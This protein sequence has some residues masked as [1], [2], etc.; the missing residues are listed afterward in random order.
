MRQYWKGRESSPMIQGTENL[1]PYD[2]DFFPMSKRPSVENLRRV[3]R[4]KNSS[5]IAHE[6]NG[7]YDPANVYIPQRPLLSHRLSQR[8][9]NSTSDGD[10]ASNTAGQ[11]VISEQPTE[12]TEN[13]DTIRTSLSAKDQISPTKSSLSKTNA[14]GEIWDDAS[15][16]LKSVTFD[17]APPQVNEYEMSTPD[18]ST[19]TSDVHEGSEGSDEAEG[20]LDLSFDPDSS[21]DRD[22]SFDASLEDI[23]KTPV[24]LPEEWRFMSPENA[25]ESQANEDGDPFTE[26]QEDNHPQSAR[27]SP[28]DESNPERR[29]LPPLPSMRIAQSPRQQR[30][31][32]THPAPASSGQS[33]DEELEYASVSLED[34]LRV[35]MLDGS[36]R[37]HEKDET[38]LKEENNISEKQNKTDNSECKNQETG[39]GHD[40]ANGLPS[41]RISRE[42]I[43]RDIRKGDNYLDESFEYPSQIEASPVPPLSL[44]EPDVPIPTLEEEDEGDEMESGSVI[45]KQEEHD[46]DDDE[47]HAIPEYSDDHHYDHSAAD[48]DR[49]VH[50]SN[51]ESQHSKQAGEELHDQSAHL[52]SSDDSVATAIDPTQPAHEGPPGNV[53]TG[54]KKE[55]TVHGDTVGEEASEEAG[56]ENK[57]TDVSDDEFSTPG[58]VVR[59][60]IEEE[61]KSEEMNI[62]PPAATVKAPGSKLRIRPSLTKADTAAMAATRR[63]VSGH[64]PPPTISFDND[65]P[66][67]S[68]R[69]AQDDS[70]LDN[71]KS[72]QDALHP[73]VPQ[74]QSSFLKLDIPFSIQEEDS[75]GLGLDKEFDRVMETQKVAQPTLS[76]GS[77]LQADSYVP[78][79][80]GY[81][82]RQNTKV[83]VASSDVGE[84]DGGEES[85]PKPANEAKNATP[86]EKP[87]TPSPRKPSQP[88]WTTVPWNGKQR[89]VSAKQGPSGLPRKKPVP[90]PVPPLPG[91]ASNVEEALAIAEENEASLNETMEDGEERGRVFVKVVGIKDLDLPLPKGMFA[92]RNSTG[93]SLFL[94]FN[95][96]GER[97]YF[98]LT[99]D[100]GLH[101]VT[102]SW[103][104]LGKS[105]PIGQ[106]FELIVQKDLEFQLTLQMKMDESKFHT[107]EPSAPS[108]SSTPVRQKTSAFSRVF[109]SPRKK[110]EMELKQQAA[111]Q[112]QPRTENPSLA[113]WQ[114]LRSLVSRDGSFG[115]SYIALSDHEQHAFGR[116]YTVDVSCFNEWATEEQPSSVRSKKSTMSI[117]SQRKPPYKIGKLELQLLYVPKPKGARDDDMPKSMSGCIREMQDAEKV[118]TQSF[119]G[120]LSQQGGDCPVSSSV[121]T[122]V[123]R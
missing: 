90:G 112:P 85:A 70:Q 50:D 13:E 15:R 80:R 122:T 53:Q 88:T 73:P 91:Q 34:K 28:G 99:L 3:S 81:L 17:A 11:N 79:Q 65:L 40:M 102:T 94:I 109:A 86:A 32:P 117:S 37:E 56:P 39:E 48:N 14:N 16:H 31:L 45:I 41:P 59:H 9:S 27:E 1:A 12:N 21:V 60:S 95:R 19:V 7:D 121:S 29:P 6:Q 107:P 104:E 101:C 116:P 97:C 36:E 30:T 66:N 84:A 33:N 76:G 115:R 47:F 82:M 52:S 105:A 46:D 22:D 20:D 64:D 113:A 87:T 68:Q 25:D 110:R 2:P 54:H 35:M 118:A 5:I 71:K 62:P 92:I 100:N 83:I 77:G 72:T 58:S 24:V 49:T 67:D 57:D 106:E 93:T 74:R 43:L 8:K 55:A 4:V 78:A 111:A 38:G 10:A 63:R 108:S 119:E 114:K 26:H 23:E 89:R 98:S 44:Y 42:S 51:D 61:R 103:L 120:F 69:S 75:L 123:L 18:V 96:L